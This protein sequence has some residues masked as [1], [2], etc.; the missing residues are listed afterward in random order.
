MPITV[1]YQVRRSEVWS[2]YWW[3]WRRG[4][5]R[6]HLLIVA[7]LGPFA[8]LMMFGGFPPD[9]R[10]WIDVT[11]AAL[12]VPA[13]LILYPQLRFKSSIRTLTIGASGIRTRI[14]SR[15]GTIAWRKIGI[16]ARENGAVIIQRTRGNAFIVPARAFASPEAAE[17]FAREAEQARTAA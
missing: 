10:G 9:L 14:G 5:W 17:A 7:M 3:L 6:S 13:L 12:A 15:G 11:G 8:S 1:E 16:V 2:L 4:L